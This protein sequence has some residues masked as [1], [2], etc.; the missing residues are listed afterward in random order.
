MRFEGEIHTLVHLGVVGV[1]VGGA[2]SIVTFGVT[3][4]VKRD[5]NPPPKSYGLYGRYVF[6]LYGRW[7]FLGMF[8]IGLIL[9]IAGVI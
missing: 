6:D 3:W 1:L 7:V 8:A 4:L 5:D 2:F 9:L